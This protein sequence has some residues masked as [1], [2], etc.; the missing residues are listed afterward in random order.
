M[1]KGEMRTVLY[2]KIENYWHLEGSTRQLEYTTN[3]EWVELHERNS[4]PIKNKFLA[5][6]NLNWNIQNLVS[7]QKNYKVPII[8]NYILIEGIDKSAVDILKNYEK[9]FYNSVSIASEKGA[10][11]F[12]YGKESFIN[13][14]IPERGVCPLVMVV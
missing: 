7:A 6:E 10:N 1:Y 3:K 14:I 12:V 2:K 4:F 13:K 9:A 8:L 5:H 11:L